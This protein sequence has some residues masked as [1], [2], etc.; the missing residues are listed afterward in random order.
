MSR[1]STLPL[2]YVVIAFGMMFGGDVAGAPAVAFI[3][4]VLVALLFLFLA[5]AIGYLVLDRLRPRIR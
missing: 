2:W 4:G 3:G 5:G 1:P